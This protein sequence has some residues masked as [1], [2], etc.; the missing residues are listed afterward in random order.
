MII[1]I[2]VIRC[3]RYFSARVL[4]DEDERER[5]REKERETYPKKTFGGFLSH[6]FPFFYFFLRRKEKTKKN[7]GHIIM[8]IMTFYSCGVPT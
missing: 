1:I 8:R 2:V 7:Y 3:L 6:Y 5:G 4:C